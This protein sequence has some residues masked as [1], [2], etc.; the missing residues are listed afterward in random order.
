MKIEKLTENKIRI[1][2]NI[3]DLA[4]KNIDI[5]TLIQNNEISQRLFKK[6]LV[7]AKKEVGF[8]VDD[9]KLLIEAFISTD[10]F[11]VLTFTKILNEIPKKSYVPIKPIPKRKSLNLITDIA[12]YKFDSF[13]DFET[14]CSN[15]NS[16]SVRNLSDFSKKISLYEYDEKYFLVFSN[17][18][19]TSP[20][21][22][23][24][25]AS[26]S[27]FA[28]LVSNSNSF[29][30]RLAEYGKQILKTKADIKKFLNV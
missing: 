11:F 6:L 10:G 27:E 5:H 23:S 29:E 2:L 24:V 17:I 7:Q 26:I 8:N 3:D 16:S 18:D 14:Y 13:E 30:S 22:N 15:V 20:K 19:I 12:I 9:C 28:T 1:V 21:L 25:F 4:K